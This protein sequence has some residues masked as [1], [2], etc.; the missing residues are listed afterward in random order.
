[1]IQ[2]FYGHANQLAFILLCIIV[3]LLVIDTSIARLYT[4]IY[5]N[6]FYGNNFDNSVIWNVLGFALI[7]ITC[8]VIQYILLKV[9]TNKTKQESM[10]GHLHL[11]RVQKLV[12]GIQY[13]IIALFVSITLQM[14]FTSSYN[15]MVL[16]ATIGVSYTLGA[17]MMSYLASRFYL[18]FKI[19]KNPVIL[20]YTLASV[21]LCTNITITLVYVL[22]LLADQPLT[23]RPHIGHMSAA[24]SE[25]SVPYLGYVLSG[26]IAF[27]LT[28][29]ATSLL[30]RHHSDRLGKVKYWLI[31]CIPLGYFFG[32]FA[33]SLLN[34][35]YQFR[36]SD[37]V[38]FGIV[39]NLIFGLSKVV[40]GILFGIAFWT[41][42]RKLGQIQVRE[43]M[44]I[45]AYGLVLLFVSNQAIFLVNYNYPPFGFATVSY[46]GF[47]CFLIMIGIYSAAISVG[48][49]VELRKLIKKSAQKE[50]GLLQ[51]IASAEM[52]QQIT[53]TVLSIARKNKAVMR[54]E[55][56]LATSL[57]D[58]EVVRYT[59]E[60]LQEVMKEKAGK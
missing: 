40:G 15:I 38:T 3:V 2:V 39:Y 26:I 17:I 12:S 24:I 59:K 58:E 60:V 18:W 16:A 55:T 11:G 32:Q 47:S 36:A 56:G 35:F 5:G 27:I 6:V 57:E 20:A 7:T 31:V 8:I 37:P 52:E 9:V 22:D 33:P 10:K 45:S 14:V 21:A 28:W 25:N 23:M 53:K 54:E 34:L 30:M 50:S 48:Q 4:I 49:D 19:N 29:I 1:M 51:Q 44:I 13:A 41:I 43:Y 42:A 46:V